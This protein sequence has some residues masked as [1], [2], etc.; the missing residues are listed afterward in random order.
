MGGAFAAEQLDVA[1]DL[2]SGLL[3]PF[4]GPVRLGMGERH[5]R[6]EDQRREAAPVGVVEIE[7][8]LAE[9]LGLR[10][11]AGGGRVVPG[12]QQGAAG[13]EGMGGGEA[14]AAEAEQRD[15]APLE[16]GDRDHQRTFNVVR[17]I[18]ARTKATIQKRTTTCG[19]D[20][21][22]CSK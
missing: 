7:Q 12:V 6:R 18:R 20:Q 15:R 9:P 5:A 8:H 21:P 14:G 2:Q 13:D 11:F 16:C 10:F 19:S 17:P 22:N 1:D 4:R 3:G